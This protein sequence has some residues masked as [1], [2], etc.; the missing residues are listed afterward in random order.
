MQAE[1]KQVAGMI[2]RREGCD[3]APRA[4]HAAGRRLRHPRHEPQERGFAAAVRGDEAEAVAFGDGKVQPGEE[5][6]ATGQRKVFES[7]QGHRGL[8]RSERRNGRRRI[9]LTM[10]RICGPGQPREVGRGAGTGPRVRSWKR[11]CDTGPTFCSIRWGQFRAFRP[12]EQHFPSCFPTS[13]PPC[14]SCLHPFAERRLSTRRPAARRPEAMSRSP[15]SARLRPAS[16]WC[17][18]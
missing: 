2:L 11:R 4:R 8:I 16:G 12:E 10:R 18:A 15:R 5:G 13:A 7:D 17:G 1:G 14:R 3:K 9:R 6:L